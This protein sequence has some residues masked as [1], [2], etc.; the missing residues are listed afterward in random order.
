LDGNRNNMD[1]NY[2]G[3]GLKIVN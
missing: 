2:H 1:S 3:V